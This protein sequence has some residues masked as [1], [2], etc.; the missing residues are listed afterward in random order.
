MAEIGVSMENVG[1]LDRHTV[2]PEP[3]AHSPGREVDLDARGD[4]D[5]R[6]SFSA[7][8]TRLNARSLTKASTQTP[9]PWAGPILSHRGVGRASMPVQRVWT[10]SHAA[11]QRQAP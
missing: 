4:L 6:P 3:H 7:R 9:V 8:G 1:D 2:E 11:G 10:L 5:H